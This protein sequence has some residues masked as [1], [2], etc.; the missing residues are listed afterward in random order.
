MNQSHG[1]K[2]KFQG[3]L[4]NLSYKSN[5]MGEKVDTYMGQRL[6]GRSEIF[7]NTCIKF[8]FNYTAIK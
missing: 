5:L 8:E 2:I 7:K 1:V 6:I 3:M 4:H